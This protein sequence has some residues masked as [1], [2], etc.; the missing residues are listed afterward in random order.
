MS[1]LDAYLFFDGNCAEAM[2]FYER[3]LG[4]K[5]EAM[6]THGDSPMAEQ[7]PP[8]SADLIMHARLALD[9]HVLMASDGMPG[10]RQERKGFSLSLTYPTAAEANKKFEALGAGGKVTMPFDKTFWAEGFGMLV[11][12]FGTPW[13]VSGGTA[14][15]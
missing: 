2:R 13:M 5:L 1:Q 9:G 6:M 7:S 10:Q 12:R 15:P 14:E 11:D 4:G 3:T 8:G